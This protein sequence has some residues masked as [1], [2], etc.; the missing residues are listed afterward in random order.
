MKFL[1]N[2]A[3][4]AILAGS[5]LAMGVLECDDAASCIKFTEECV[6]GGVKVCIGGACNEY[7]GMS[8]LNIYASAGDV[9]VPFPSA[10]TTC[11]AAGNHPCNGLATNGVKWDAPEGGPD[12]VPT[13]DT[14]EYCAVVPFGSVVTYAF[15][16]A[17]GCT[18]GTMSENLGWECKEDCSCNGDG[19]KAACSIEQQVRN[20]DGGPGGPGGPGPSP[21]PSPDDGPGM[22]GDPHLKS[23]KGEW[24][25]YMG[26][27]DLKLLH[28]PSF[29][30][31]QDLDIHVRT[32]IQFTYS[33]IEAAA[34][35]IGDDV[36]EVGG[37]GDFAFNG[38]DGGMRTDDMVPKM[39][40]Y[41]VYYTMKDKK[42]HKFDVVVGE[43]KNI[44]LNTFKD[45]VSVR[46]YDEDEDAFGAASGLLG[47]FDGKMLS[48]D[49]TDM[50]DDM[51]A[52]GQDWQ[53]LPEEGQ[54]FRSVRAPQY[55]EAC[56][57]PESKSAGAT[58]RRLGQKVVSEE[59]AKLACS[60]HTGSSYNFCFH[61]VM[62]AQDLELANS[63]AF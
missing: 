7:G 22:V 26:E 59:A 37:W 21:S 16:K 52:L 45:W 58:S 4:F 25:D 32:K 63:G 17:M 8:H 27:C 46:V 5:A 19:N 55:P 29:D 31:K 56:I 34:L 51:N 15:K 62:A 6:D 38:V 24:F 54:L 50:S 47:T 57:L 14:E 2:I 23:W 44:T 42:R 40:G 10:S 9:T 35:K 28:A 11:A 13:D 33:Y 39:G 20:C 30:G 53:I 61:D 49:G 1:L 43:G 36:L 18:L 48:R 60:K 3:T 12:L 41:Q